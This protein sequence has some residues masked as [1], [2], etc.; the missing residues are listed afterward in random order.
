[1]QSQ[2]F[3]G[4]AWAVGQRCTGVDDTG[5]RGAFDAGRILRTHVLRPTWHLVVPADLR[6]MLALTAPRVHAANATYYRRSELDAPTLTRGADL[7]CRSLAGGRQLT[8]T[9]LRDVL[10]AG[11]VEPGDA[12]RLGL[13]VMWCEL[14][15]LICSGAMRGKQH[16]YALVDER[17]PPALGLAGDEAFGELARRYF[18]SHGPAQIADFAWWSGLTVTE[19]G[20]AADIAGSGAPESSSGSVPGTSP[21]VHLLP[22]FDEYVVAYQDRSALFATADL[23]RELAGM[24][25]LSSAPVLYRGQLAG[26][27][28][29]SAARGRV[30]LTV[31]LRRELGPAG[32]RALSAAATRYGRFLALPV[33]LEYGRIDS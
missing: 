21:T 10:S 24:G 30:V 11:G 27:W 17:I 1:V 9:E 23:A 25:V 7:I 22:N 8:R 16:T 14:E 2:E 33:E 12:L 4:S 18:A 3:A 29:R 15:A 32:Q 6:W 5:F 20:R 26:H 31:K 19:A 13:I 28:Q